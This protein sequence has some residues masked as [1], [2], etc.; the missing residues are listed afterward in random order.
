MSQPLNQCVH[1]LMG[2]RVHHLPHNSMESLW[3]KKKKEGLLLFVT[4][5][6]VPHARYNVLDRETEGVCMCIVAT[7]QLNYTITRPMNH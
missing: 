5:I 1:N 4:P 6:P 3:K 7:P 2:E